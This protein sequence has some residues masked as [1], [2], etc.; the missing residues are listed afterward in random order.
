MSNGRGRGKKKNT[1]LKF[2]W[3]KKKKGGRGEGG[4]RGDG[5]IRQLH[6][7]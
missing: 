1:L 3:R 2:A 6:V 4:V 5:R 7:H